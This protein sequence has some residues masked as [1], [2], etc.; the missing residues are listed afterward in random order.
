M[1]VLGSAE[2]NNRAPVQPESFKTA[3]SGYDPRDIEGTPRIVRFFPLDSTDMHLVVKNSNVYIYFSERMDVTT[4]TSMN[5]RLRFGNQ[6]L[7]YEADYVDKDGEH[8]LTLN[9]DDLFPSDAFIKLTINDS[10][11]DVEGTP[12]DTDDDGQPGGPDFELTFRTSK[13]VDN[14]GPEISDIPPQDDPFGSEAV[15]EIPALVSDT[16]D[17][18]HSIIIECESYIGDNPDDGI[19]FSVN[20]V[21]GVF[22][23][24]AEN[25][26]VTIRVADLPEGDVFNVKITATDSCGNICEPAIVTIERGSADFLFSD[27]VFA[28]PNPCYGDKVR[29]Y[30]FV[31]G[32]TTV[33]VRIYDM[34]G[35]LVDELSGETGGYDINPYLEWDVGDA[36]PG[37]YIFS[38]SVTGKGITEEVRKKFALLR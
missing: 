10:V 9:P 21:D 32:E 30:F 12:L 7:P 33:D 27:R 31:T 3:G 28:I 5:V 23:E 19:T 29:F 2:Y 34:K 24:E 15:I 1:P 14:D 36:A 26:I 38:L 11:T 16:G 8:R 35:R 13:N 20:P 22:D 6:V 17:Y 25:I 4:F 37:I 18:G